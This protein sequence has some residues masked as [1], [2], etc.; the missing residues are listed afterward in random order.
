MK[1]Y[2]LQ[3]ISRHFQL[4]NTNDGFL[5]LGTTSELPLIGITTH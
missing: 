3:D 4:L 2:E 5:R 1:K